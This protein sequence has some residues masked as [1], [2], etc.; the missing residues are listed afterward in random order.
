MKEGLERAL[1]YPV[2]DAIFKRRSRRFGAGMSLENSVMQFK[3]KIKPIPLSE[4]EEALII[5]AGVGLTGVNLGDLPPE[6]GLSTIIQWTGRTFPSACNAHATELFYTNDDG[7]YMMKLRDAKVDKVSIFE[8]VNSK[9]EMVDM[10][11]N[12]FRKYRLKLKNGR[13]DLPDSPPGLFE[14]NVWNAN[15][16]GSTLFFPVTDLTIWYIDLLMLYS[17]RSYGITI[18]DEM[19]G[20]RTVGVDEWVRKGRLNANLKMPLYEFEKRVVTG[21]VVEQAIICHNLNLAAQAMGLGGW[22]FTGFLPF[23]ALGGSPE[24]EGLGFRFVTPKNGGTPVPVGRD[25]VF[26][27]YCPPYYK[28]MDEAVEAWIKDKERYWSEAEYPYKDKKIVENVRF[29]SDTT[30]Q[31]VK[32]ICNYIYDT[33]G[34]FPAFIEPMF[35]RLQAQVHHLD[36]EFYD[37][38]FKEGAYSDVHKKHFELWHPDI[39]I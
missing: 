8:D 24:H 34:R 5:W 20:G 3:S 25:G 38:Y 2:F 35:S 9:E 22:T 1:N 19:H 26:E 6:R 33:Y 37:T 14:F 4:V 11:L 12:L 30:V 39:E 36:P 15:K 13:A 7:L 31:I 16:P 10:I 32:D 21:M 18:I 29:Y 17:S 23:Y 28:D 27:A